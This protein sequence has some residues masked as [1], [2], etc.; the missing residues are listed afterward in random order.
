[1]LV[2]IY[3]AL[4][5]KNFNR[6]ITYSSVE[7]YF[8]KIIFKLL[9]SKFNYPWTVDYGTHRELTA[10]GY[11]HSTS[12]EQLFKNIDFCKKNNAPFVF[13]THYWD[14]LNNPSLHHNLLNAIDDLSSLKSISEIINEE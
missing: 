13:A 12:I 7:F 4:C 2:L 10:Y 1:M 5:I 11:S 8:K 14:L 3:Q 9:H 6:P